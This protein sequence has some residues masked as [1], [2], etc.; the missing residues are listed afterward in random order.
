[1]ISSRDGGPLRESAGVLVSHF[2]AS[3]VDGR[4]HR[5][6]FVTHDQEEAMDLP[7]GWQS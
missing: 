3:D 7:T 6:V 2:S 4:K 1:L 5:A